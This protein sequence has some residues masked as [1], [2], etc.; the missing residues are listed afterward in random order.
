MDFSRKWFPGC[1]PRLIKA[2]IGLFSK[3][4]DISP[5]TYVELFNLITK[6][7]EYSTSTFKAASIGSHQMLSFDES[8][9]DALLTPSSPSESEQLQA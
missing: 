4:G 9:D 3:A 1:G 5:Q 2:G 7:P 8:E 6:W